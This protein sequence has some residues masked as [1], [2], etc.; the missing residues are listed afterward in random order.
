[1]SRMKG[2]GWVV[3]EA[4]RGKRYP[5][6]TALGRRHIAR[7]SLGDLQ[8]H[9]PLRWDGRWRIVIFDVEEKKQNDRAKIRRLLQ[10]LGFLLLQRSVWVYPYDCEEIIALIKTD[11]RTGRNVLYII[12]DAIEYDRPLREHFGL[13]L[14][15]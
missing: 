7:I 12:A 5:R 2:K 10:R 11:M 15:N 9:K 1:M 3:F 14:N 4:V 6:L 8:I 13:A